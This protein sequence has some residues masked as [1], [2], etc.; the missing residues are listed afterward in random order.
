MPLW[1][2]AVVWVAAWAACRF[3]A[4]RW[5]PGHFAATHDGDQVYITG[6]CLRDTP[7][8]L[9]VKLSDLRPLGGARR[10]AAFVATV[11]AFAAEA[12]WALLA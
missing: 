7:A 8:G 6:E 9:W 11:V 5:W 10:W 12:A 4:C 2:F 3:V 1:L